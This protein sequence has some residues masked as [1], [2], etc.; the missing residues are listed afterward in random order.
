MYQYRGRNVKVEKMFVEVESEEIKCKT[1]EHAE[2]LEVMGRVAE[3][4]L[5]WLVNVLYKKSD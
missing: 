1:K 4:Q 2:M 3:E 5:V